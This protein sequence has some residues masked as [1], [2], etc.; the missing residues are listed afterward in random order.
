MGIRQFS[1]QDSIAEV[2]LCPD[3]SLDLN[4]DPR[5]AKDPRSGGKKTLTQ[6]GYH[7]CHKERIIPQKREETHCD[8]FS[9]IGYRYNNYRINLFFWYTVKIY[10]CQTHMLVA[11]NFGIKIQIYV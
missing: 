8:T 3:P 2:S 7:C 5:V 4:S 9:D 11:P 10:W 1:E 6:T